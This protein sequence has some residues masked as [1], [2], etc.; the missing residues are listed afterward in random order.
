MFL[1]EKKGEKS[2]WDQQ[3][4]FWC[5]KTRFWFRK[6]RFWFRKTRFWCTIRYASRGHRTA[7]AEAHTC[8]RVASA[9]ARYRPGTARVSTGLSRS[10]MDVTSRAWVV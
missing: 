10:R 8:T 3:K 4:R 2:F 9:S 1:R 5:R 7:F 6:T